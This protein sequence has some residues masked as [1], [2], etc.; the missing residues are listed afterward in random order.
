MVFADADY[1]EAY[2]VSER[3]CFKQHAEML[4]RIPS[5]TGGVNGSAT[6]LSMPICICW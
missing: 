6:K 5:L 2:L 4:R 1:I 3:D